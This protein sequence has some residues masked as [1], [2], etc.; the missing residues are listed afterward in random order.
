M[1]T[2]RLVSD[3]GGGKLK[4]FLHLYKEITSLDNLFQAWE[5]FKK[6]K[7]KKIDVGSFERHLED[8]IFELHQALEN[9]T[10]RHSYYSGFYIRDPKVR[11]IHKAVVKD[12][13]VHHAL[14]KILNPIF[15]PS[16]ISSSFSC[17]KGY[18]THKGFKR[19]VIYARKVSKNYTQDCWALKC[20]IRKFFDSVD[21]YVL[22]SFLKEKIKDPDTIWLLEEIIQSFEAKGQALEAKKGIPIGNLT[23]QLFANVYLNQLDQFLKHK[24]KMRYYL[25]YADDFILLYQNKEELTKYMESIRHFLA[26]KLKLSLHPRKVSLRKFSWGIDFVGYVALP[27]HQVLRTKTKKRIFRKISRKVKDYRRGE[28]G[29]VTLNQSIQSYLGILKH[30]DAYKLEQEL[31][32]KIGFWLI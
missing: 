30:A 2:S 32:N 29:E 14:F 11:H 21:H 13:I 8:N 5:E 1:G 3:G 16:F 20:D 22:L 10:Y 6:D 12:R 28:I 26:E 31:K 19:L 15:E 4:T 27:H 23:S 25:R 24:L 7:R 17:R 9:K 18:G